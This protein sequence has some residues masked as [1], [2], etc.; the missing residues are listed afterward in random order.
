[1]CVQAEASLDLCV[2]QQYPYSL[3]GSFGWRFRACKLKLSLISVPYTIRLLSCASKSELG[4]RTSVGAHVD[5][6]VRAR[7]RG[8]SAGFQ[9][10]D[11][12]ESAHH[13]PLNT[14]TFTHARPQMYV[15]PVL[16]LKSSSVVGSCTVQRSKIALACTHESATQNSPATNMDIVEVHR[17]QGWLQLARTSVPP[18]NR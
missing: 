2:T 10:K 18:M 17:G 11:R 7:S 6:C 5:V 4:P 15:G 3:Q 16:I 14:H 8:C 13:G 1:M 12:R 9:N